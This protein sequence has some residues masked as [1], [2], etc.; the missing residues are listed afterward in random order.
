MSIVGQPATGGLPEGGCPSCGYGYVEGH[1]FGF[2]HAAD[3]KYATGFGSPYVACRNRDCKRVLDP[4][5]VASYGAMT[6]ASGGRCRAAAWRQATG[7]GR[8]DG[9]QEPREARTNGSPAK[10]PRASGQQIAYGRAVDALTSYL[11][12]TMHHELARERAE[13]I[14]RG[15]LSERQRQQLQQ[16]EETRP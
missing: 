7:Y 10:R 3:C 12:Q 11:H 13:H 5:R 14:L 9:P 1:G 6:C 8:H 16:R 15:A 4:V 2:V